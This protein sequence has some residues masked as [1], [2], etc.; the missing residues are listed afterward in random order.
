MAL[1]FCPAATPFGEA[2]TGQTDQGDRGGGSA[3]AWAL[4]LAQALS[5]RWTGHQIAWPPA[6]G[7]W[8]HGRRA[9]RRCLSSLTG[10]TGTAQARRA[11]RVW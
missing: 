11:R 4:A 6:S 2:T 8:T 1:V 7:L 9:L 10:A 5:P 3:Q